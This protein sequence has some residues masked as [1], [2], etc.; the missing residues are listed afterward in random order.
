MIVPVIDFPVPFVQQ[1]K[2]RAFFP[3]ERPESGKAVMRIHIDHQV[4]AD[5]FEASGFDD[6]FRELFPF[7]LFGKSNDPGGNVVTLPSG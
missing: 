4:S 6:R 2:D 5:M 1:R 3:V 7:E